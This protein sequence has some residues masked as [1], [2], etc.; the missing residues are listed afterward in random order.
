MATKY[1]RGGAVAVQQDSRGT[2][3]GVDATPADNDFTVT[4]GGIAVSVAG[5]TD[6]ATTAAALVAAMEASTH[7]YF[8]AVTWT[9]PSGG[10][11][12]GVADTAG[13]PFTPA[14]SVSGTGSGSVT[15]F[16]DT[17]ANAGPNDVS[18]ADNYDDGALPT[19][20]DTLVIANTDQSLLWDLDHFTS[21]DITLII[22]KSFTGRI[23][24][25]AQ[26]VES[27]TSGKTETTDTDT[28]AQ[29][30]R[31]RYLEIAPAASSRHEIGRNPTGQSQTGSNR[32]YIDFGS[33]AQEIIVH[34][35]ASSPNEDYALAIKAASASTDIFVRKAPGGFGVAVLRGDETS[36][37]GDLTVEDTSSN[38]KVT[39][40]DGVTWTNFYQY[41]GTNRINAAADVTLIS[42]QGG[43]LTTEGD[44]LAATIETYN[45]PTLYANHIKTGGNAVTAADIY[46]GTV[47]TTQSAEARTWATVTLREPDVEFSKHENVTITT[48]ALPSGRSI[49][50][51]TEAA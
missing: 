19:A 24:L 5:D 31:T 21:T 39:L 47:D 29:E 38:A 42:V 22:D 27:V 12:K 20:G 1:W 46:G 3:D 36:T 50:M 6:V 34:D 9:N 43:T 48:L 7:P 28:Y 14:L 37:I 49:T 18:T 23:G 25:P 8:A 17:T 16:S 4:I 40:S 45:S 15:D 32:I 2:I 51:S 10:T 33:N 44:W 11:I 35:T 41:G 13:I 30:Y 26:F